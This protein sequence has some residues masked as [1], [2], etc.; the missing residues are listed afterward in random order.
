MLQVLGFLKAAAFFIAIIMIVRYGFQMIRSYEK[1][2]QLKLGKAG[3]VN[4]L[5]ALVFIKVIDYIFFIA[6]SNDFKSKVGD[7]II[8]ASK[9][10][11]YVIGAIMLLAVFY[12]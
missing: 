2:D 7:G 3:V 1:D 4:V 5:A 8:A 6:Q 10:A 12:A 11:G 9:I